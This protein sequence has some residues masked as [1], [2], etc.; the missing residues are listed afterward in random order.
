[1]ARYHKSGIDSVCN[2]VVRHFLSYSHDLLLFLLLSD[3][4][5]SNQKKTS[6]MFWRTVAGGSTGTRP[7][8]III[9]MMYVNPVIYTTLRLWFWFSGASGTKPTIGLTKAHTDG[10]HAAHAGNIPCASAKVVGYNALG[11][12][13]PEPDPEVGMGAPAEYLLNSVKDTMRHTAV[14]L[15][16][17][18]PAVAPKRWCCVWPGALCC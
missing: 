12:S 16:R 2:G 1:M 9:L 17:G 14:F 3:G 11:D 10:V 6:C 4:L 13:I 7:G 5:V 18:V 8:A 15:T